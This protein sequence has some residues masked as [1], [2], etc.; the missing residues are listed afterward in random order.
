MAR[1]TPSARALLHPSHVDA[2]EALRA[3]V[4]MLSVDSGVPHAG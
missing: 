4:G 2:T 1:S 3:S